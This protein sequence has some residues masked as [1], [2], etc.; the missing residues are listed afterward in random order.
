VTQRQITV[1]GRPADLISNEL[2]GKTTHFLAFLPAEGETYLEIR[3]TF[4]EE[5]RFLQ[6]LHSL[7]QVDVDT[8]ISA[9]PDTVVFRDDRAATV[10]EML[11]GVQIPPS[12]DLGKLRRGDGKSVEDRIQIAGTVALAV[13]CHWA[14][15]WAEAT[16]AGDEQTAAE[17]QQ[18]LSAAAAD[19][20]LLDEDQST[21]GETVRAMAAQVEAGTYPPVPPPQ[22]GHNGIV[23][24]TTGCSQLVP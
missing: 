13:G 7:D 8:W 24:T 10:D 19:W 23:V 3:G 12:L 20:R 9:M 6:L 22:Q 15:T 2:G 14:D 5:A 11:Q 16:R 21:M 1:L 18:A 4:T 17:A